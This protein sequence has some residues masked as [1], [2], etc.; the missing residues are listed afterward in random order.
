[1]QQFLDWLVIEWGNDPDFS[2][3]LF[4]KIERKGKELLEVES[5]QHSAIYNE[6]MKKS[7]GMMTFLYTEVEGRVDTLHNSRHKS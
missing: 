7:E 1:M 5:Q 2:L 4:D 6:G 3:S